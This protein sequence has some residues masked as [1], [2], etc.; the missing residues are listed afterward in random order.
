M[1]FITINSAMIEVGEPTK[2]ELFE[3]IKDNFDDHEARISIA[4]NAV[5]QVT[6]LYFD[7]YGNYGNYGARE[8]VFFYK[9]SNNIFVQSV[10]I[11][12]YK[13]G[14]SGTTTADVLYKR[15]S[16]P[17]VSLLSSLPTVTSANGDLYTD[18]GILSEQDLEIDD[19]LR[20]DLTS[21]QVTGHDSKISIVIEYEVI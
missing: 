4:E 9:L 13:A 18:N 12:Q 14:V 21:T 19:W 16:D 5:N 3:N 10:K 2:K 8:G 11:N 7:V 15:G 1:A 6:P 17:F 20:V